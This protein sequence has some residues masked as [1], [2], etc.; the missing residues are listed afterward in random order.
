M[1]L[2]PYPQATTPRTMI[3]AQY[4]HT[5]KPIMI[6]PVIGQSAPTTPTSFTLPVY[7]PPQPAPAP[8]V[9]HPL[10]N[11]NQPEAELLK[12]VGKVLEESVLTGQNK[13]KIVAEWF[14]GPQNPS[15]QEKLYN[16][17][18]TRVGNT[19]YY[20]GVGTETQYNRLKSLGQEEIGCGCGGKSKT[21]LRFL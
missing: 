14:F 2:S 10:L 9:S 5:E 6:S 11:T 21:K 8:V 12:E 17:I 7:V 15:F 3:H 13:V 18:L 4:T 19:K 20:Q 1:A 16:I